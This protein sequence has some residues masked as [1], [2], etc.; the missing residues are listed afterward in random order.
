MVDRKIHVCDFSK[1]HIPPSEDFGQEHAMDSFGRAL[2]EIV[3]VNRFAS[4]VGTL[5]KHGGVF[6]ADARVEVV[7]ADALHHVGWGAV[8]E[9]ALAQQAVHF[10]HTP[11]H[12]LLLPVG[13]DRDTGSEVCTKKGSQVIMQTY[14]EGT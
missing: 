7:L 5:A 3:G 4:K 9:V 8:E 12:V 14:A 1:L 11:W 2:G 6:P 13:F 10:R